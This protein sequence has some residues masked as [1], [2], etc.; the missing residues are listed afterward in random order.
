MP[1]SFLGASCLFIELFC[2]ESLTAD[3]QILTSESWNLGRLRLRPDRGKLAEPAVAT[4]ETW[5]V[6]IGA[7]DRAGPASR[8][9]IMLIPYWLAAA[10]RSSARLRRTN[11]L[12]CFNTRSGLSGA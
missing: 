2:C 11:W 8:V 6:I 9:V 7:G 12:V 10:L 5:I 4:G 3:W 1:K